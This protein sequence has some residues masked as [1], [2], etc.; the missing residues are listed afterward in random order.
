M[1]EEAVLDWLCL[2]VDPAALPRRFAGA[3]RS[4]AAGAGVRVVAK[5][6][7]QAAALRRCFLTSLGL[8][9]NEHTRNLAALLLPLFFPCVLAWFAAVL[10]CTPM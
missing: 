8:Q 9:N 7:E 4:A 3:A 5:A 6:D 10:P 1:S 2:H